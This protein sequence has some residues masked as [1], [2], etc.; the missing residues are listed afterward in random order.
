MRDGFLLCGLKAMDLADVNALAVRDAGGT[1]KFPAMAIRAALRSGLRGWENLLGDNDQ[2][3]E[4]GKSMDANLD[5]LPFVLLS[6]L[7]GKVLEASAL[8]S[9]QAKLTIA[10]VVAHDRD[11]FNC[12]ACRFHRHCDEQPGA[13]PHVRAAGDRHGEQYLPS[14]DGD[15]RV[16]RVSQAVRA[17]QERPAAVRWRDLRSAGAVRRGHG[18]HRCAGD[19]AEAGG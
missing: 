14:A 19:E 8:G 15:A 16:A 9:E 1:V 5:R 3:V 10:V 4:F 17:L 2:P 6:E 7:F 18:L 11:K 12:R 13:V